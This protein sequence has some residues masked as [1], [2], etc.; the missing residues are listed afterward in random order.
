MMHSNVD[1]LPAKSR[2]LVVV[3]DDEFTLE[4][5]GRTLRRSSWAVT[6]FLDAE[7]A[8]VHLRQ[9]QPPNA[10][11][12]DQ[13]MPRIDGEDF[14]RQLIVDEEISV[15]RTFLWS[16]VDPQVDVRTRVER[17]GVHIL[18]KNVLR[19][20]AELLKALEQECA[21]DQIL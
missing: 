7:E 6:G 19:E 17:L 16:S 20:K 10:L 12:V 13:R 14:L 4:I 11:I 5:V 1:G 15:A 8:L 21:R 3:D 2:E 9:T 18:S